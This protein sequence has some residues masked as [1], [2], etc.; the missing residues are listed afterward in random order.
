MASSQ[1]IYCMICGKFYKTNFNL[2]RGCV[3]SWRCWDDLNWR[4]TLANLGQ[5]YYP[6]PEEAQHNKLRY[7]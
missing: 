6:I 7:D 4:E 3:C 1:P 5:E 2:F